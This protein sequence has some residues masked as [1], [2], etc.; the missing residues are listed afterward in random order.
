MS[1]LDAVGNDCLHS[2]EATRAGLRCTLCG[3]ELDTTRTEAD[4]K[5]ARNRSRRER[6]AIARATLRRIDARERNMAG[7][8]VEP[9]DDR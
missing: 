5:E 4:R 2:F 9:L 8:G 1:I 7:P 6:L 3:F